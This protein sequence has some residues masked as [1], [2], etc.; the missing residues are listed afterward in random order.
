VAATKEGSKW[1]LRFEQHDAEFLN[2]RRRAK[3]DGQKLRSERLRFR[4][5]EWTRLGAG[6]FAGHAG[7]GDHWNKPIVFHEESRRLFVGSCGAIYGG[8]AER[9][10]SGIGLNF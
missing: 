10:A 8:V 6:G 5:G 7:R 3:I 2:G 1:K 9:H 4:F